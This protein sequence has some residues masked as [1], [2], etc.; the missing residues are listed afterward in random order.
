[1]WFINDAARAI[2]EDVV[3]RVLGLKGGPGIRVTNTPQGITISAIEAPPP[4]TIGVGGSGVFMAKVTSNSGWAF[5]GS[6]YTLE[7]VI[8][9]NGSQAGAG[10]WIT[11]GVSLAPAYNGFEFGATGG[12]TSH[13]Y[14]TGNLITNETTGAVNNTS[15]VVKP[16]GVGAVVPT[17]L[18]VD[19]ANVATYIFS[20]ANSAQ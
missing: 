17:M 5:P 4:S 18:T 13:T 16:I 6:S 15:C 2:L 19:S 1:M 7:R 3:R 20:A 8:S 14:G 9:Y 11:D 12:A 10:R